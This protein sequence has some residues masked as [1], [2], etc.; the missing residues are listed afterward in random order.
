MVTLRVM[1]QHASGLKAMDRNGSSDPYAKLTLR[2]E[3]RTSKTVKKTLNPRWDEHFEWRGSLREL[4]AAPLQL[5]LFD[6]DMLSKDDRLGEASI[7]LRRLAHAP[8][9]DA[10][11][12][13]NT[14][15]RVHLSCSWEAAQ[16][17]ADP[18]AD[19]VAAV[20]S[21]AAQ[22][23]ANQMAGTAFAAPNEEQLER[24]LSRLFEPHLEGM[25]LALQGVEQQCTHQRQALQRLDARL[26]E[27]KDEARERRGLAA[28]TGGG[29]LLPAQATTDIHLRLEGF[30]QK[31]AATQAQG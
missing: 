11:V 19:A 9:C 29:T 4:L 17:T 14:Q 5:S 20:A 22:Y 23:C 27:V 18:L 21:P 16:A 12:P 2:G 15:G 25:A 31:F 3:T 13:L 26:D 24:M 1:L 6:Y 7:D 28:P 10:T 30:L 8:R